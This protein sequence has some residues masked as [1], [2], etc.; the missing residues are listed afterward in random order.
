MSNFQAHFSGQ[1]LRYLL[2]NC[3]HMNVT[4]PYIWYINIGSGNG[5]VL[6]GNKSLPEPMLTQISVAC[7][8]PSHYLNQC[9]NIVNSNLRNKFQWNLKWSSYIFFQELAL[10]NVFCEMGEILPQPQCVNSMWPCDTIWWY[11]SGSIRALIMVCCLTA[12]SHFL[13]QCC[14]I[15]SEVL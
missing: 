9:W 10:E 3:P 1:W 13:N 8:V 11:T 12:K 6:S 15:I 14:L 7:S 4:V 2:C 5:L